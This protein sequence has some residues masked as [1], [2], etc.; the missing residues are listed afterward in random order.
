MKDSTILSG[1]IAIVNQILPHR[2][3]WAWDLFIKAQ[4]NTWVPTEVSM[5]KD[6]EQWR[7][8]DVLSEDERLL[9]RRCLG[10]FAGSE[11]LVANNLLLTI[12]KYVSDA[13]CRQYILRQAFEEALHNQTIVYICD[14]LSLDI[15]EVYEA[16]KSIPSIKAKDDFLM[17]I[18]TDMSR[19]GFRLPKKGEANWVEARQEILRSIITFYIICEGIFFYSGF[20]MLL[21][22]GRQNKMPGVAEQVNFSMRD[23]SLHL[24]FG[25]MLINVICEQEPEAWTENFKEE[26]TEHIRKTTELEIAYAHDVLPRGIMGLNA[27]QFVSYM[28]FIANRRLEGI[29]LTPIFKNPKNPFPWLTET[30]DLGKQKNFFE[31]RVIDYQKSGFVDDL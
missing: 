17:G 12:F 15:N 28:H 2:N 11:S 16:H 9:L 26:I 27:G 25:T 14:S 4:A 10:F 23:E 21:A 3:K 30:I 6:V 5:A 29:G 31:T 18:T 1:E 22:F 24:Q 8:K 20:A 13:E 19:E 7:S